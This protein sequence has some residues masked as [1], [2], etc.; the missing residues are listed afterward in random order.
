MKK[1]T[2]VPNFTELEND[3]L[4]FW[5]EDK[6]FEKLVEKNK[7]AKKH[8]KFL[9][10][11]AT[12][13]YALGIHH[14]WGRTLKDL[15]LKY[16]SMKGYSSMFQNGF[17]AHGLPVENS[18]ERELGI[19][20]KKEILS[21]GLDKFVDSC[22]DRVKK[23]SD[24]QT[25]QSKRLG[26]W[27][28]WENSYYTNSDENILGIWHFLKECFERGWVKEDHKPLKWC[29]RCGTSLS[30]HEMNGSYKDMEHM[31][32]FFKLPLTD[33]NEKILVWTTTPWTLSSNVAI[34]VN[35]DNDYIKVRV[36]SDDSLIILG[37]EAKSVLKG[38]IVE[39][40]E[41]IKGSD[42]V[43]RT[44]ETCFPE[45]ECQ[46]FTH[47]I[48][49][50]DEV[51][52]TD[53][54]GAVHIAPGCGAEDYELGKKLG[55]PII[56]PIDDLGVF[57]SEF[58][59]LAGKKTDEVVDLV[60]DK[61]K[62]DN[63]LYY[64]HAFTHSYPVC[65]RCKEPIVIRFATSWFISVDEIRPKLID[66]ARSVKWEPEFMVKR[67]ENWLENM[68]DWDIARK[69]FYGVPLPIY[70]CEDCGNVHVVGSMEELRE[71]SGKDCKM[72][73]IH[74]PYVDEI[75]I[76]C[77]KCSSKVKRIADVGVCWLDAGIAAFTTKKYFEDKA[78]FNEN[79]PS[80]VVIEM[81]EQIRLWFYSLLFMSVVLEGKAPYKRVVAHESVIQENGDRFSKS[82]YSVELLD[83]LNQAGA[84]V[85]RYLFAGNLL[86]TDVRFSFSL[87][88][89][90]RR[91]ILNFWNIYG[92]YNTYAVI[93]NPKLEGYKLDKSKLTSSDK[94]LLSVVNNFL[95]SAT[96]AY[97]DYKPFIVVREFEKVV[98]DIS[99]FYIRI[100]R[101]RFWKSGEEDDKLVAYYALYTAIKSITLVM[102]P[103]IPFLG[104]YI[105]KN[106]IVETENLSN[107]S[108]L[109]DSFPE[110]DES[111]I[112][113]EILKD[114]E[115]AR[116]VIATALALRN[117]NNLKIKQP[118]NTLFVKCSEE[119]SKAIESLKDIILS[120][121]NIK[122]I[123]FVED[124]NRFNDSYLILNF[125]EAGQI[126]KDKVQE[127]KK[128]LDAL[129]DEEMKNLVDQY[130]SGNVA[131]SG[132]ENLSS[133]IFIKKY[134]PKK[135]FVVST[136]N[137]M[138]IAIDTVI[139][140]NLMREGSLRELVRNIQILRKE[141]GFDIDERV[142]IYME[143]EDESL[144]ELI[145]SSLEFIMNEV[146]AVNF[147]E[148]LKVASDIT[149]SVEVASKN[150]SIMLKRNN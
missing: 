144:N 139:D 60:F 67:M 68:G 126:L 140:E 27:M 100:N 80:D 99:N 108:V 117:E 127:V 146:L 29:P 77:P 13:N 26:Q 75:E 81:R 102:T 47:N 40:V 149:R 143:S 92:F 28:D 89:G 34:A 14:A 23:Y 129:T 10:G 132:F 142:N 112:D 134:K 63:K 120:E 118:L 130:A 42:L 7:G 73:H 46:N 16:K 44:Y 136:E 119:N 138:V 116:Y 90:V 8:F 21:Y 107:S 1:E 82:G 61:L 114:T 106:L 115:V 24:L 66:A 62:A 148:E 49:A 15:F 122:N 36:K 83:A 71:L 95:K 33:S 41:T 124:E 147:T 53:G 141:A 19:N 5:E 64:S 48:V 123:E 50:W 54:S 17:D 76:N 52:A 39:I 131:I 110:V 111:F 105:Y 125:R 38:D 30:D 58:G 113:E 103:I 6:S 84:D 37:K 69:R 18:V 65:W 56:M 70:K 57:T 72:P 74:R 135:E 3:I 150:V 31:A 109:L 25:E 101:R 104:E 2:G 94:W 43:G 20:S 133:D 11:P 121:L 96:E 93:D 55:L 22:M 35:A 45:L 87:G 79:F 145:N 12:A 91:K 137:D 98:D 97:D 85:C 32:V 86:T 59:F 128:A 51:S 9:D 4:K 78:F 88:E